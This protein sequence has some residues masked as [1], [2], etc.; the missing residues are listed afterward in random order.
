[1]C[2]KGNP[3]TARGFDLPDWAWPTLEIYWRC[4]A[5]F[6]RVLSEA[7]AADPWLTEHLGIIDQVYREHER[8]GMIRDLVEILYPAKG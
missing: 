1:L 4:R 3:E 7:E 8:D 5:T 2:K 6:G